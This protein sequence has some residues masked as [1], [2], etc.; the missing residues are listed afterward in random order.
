[1]RQKAEELEKRLREQQAEQ[2]RLMLAKEKRLRDNRHAKVLLSSV[3]CLLFPSTVSFRLRDLIGASAVVAVSCATCFCCRCSKL[4]EL[5]MEAIP[6]VNEVNAMCEEMAL[7]QR[8]AVIL[9][10]NQDKVAAT[11]RKGK[12]EYFETLVCLHFRI[13]CLVGTLSCTSRATV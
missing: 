3:C 11:I 5:M 9:L 13:G 8:F 10:A 6:R 12:E 4:D 7:P 1:M 2:E